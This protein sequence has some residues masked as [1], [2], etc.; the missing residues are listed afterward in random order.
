MAVLSILLTVV[1]VVVSILIV[2]IVLLQRPKQEGLGAAFGG[3]TLD[4]ALGAQT[5]NVLQKATTIF[6]GIF[7][8]CSIGLAMVKTREF[9]N[10]GSKNVLD[11]LGE[12]E[13]ALPNIPAGISSAPLEAPLTLPDAKTA[14]AP[15]TVAPAPGAPAAPKTAEEKPPAK[16]EAPKEPEKAPAP[17]PKAETEKPAPKN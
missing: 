1:L 8:L 11:K 5:T 6:A 12:Q 2:M 4:G 14:P 7:F 10:T 17:A 15:G 13:A 9:D 3:S 16:T